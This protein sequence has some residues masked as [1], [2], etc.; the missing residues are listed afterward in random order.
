M[1]RGIPAE[2]FLRKKKWP[3]KLGGIARVNGIPAQLE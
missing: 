2:A 3:G 1:S